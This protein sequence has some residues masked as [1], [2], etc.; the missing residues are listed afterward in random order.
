MRLKLR[1]DRLVQ[2]AAAATLALT[3]AALL[4][5]TAPATAAPALDLKPSIFTRHDYRKCP[6]APAAGEGPDA[7]MCLGVAN[8]PVVWSSDGASAALWFGRKPLKESLNLG[9]VFRP[10]P[11]VE[12]RA[13]EQSQGRPV[14][15]IVRYRV[16]E[17]AGALSGSRVVVYRLEPS[18]AGCVMAVL[19]SGDAKKARALADETANSFRCGSSRRVAG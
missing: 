4:A 7:R 10:E 19:P 18:G 14:A 3:A 6:A 11:S 8:V 2:A 16:G 17:R 15:A 13:T 1:G 5:G 9:T 12:W